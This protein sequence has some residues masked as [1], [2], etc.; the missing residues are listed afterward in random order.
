MPTD[1]LGITRRRLNSNEDKP[2]THFD[3]V[4]PD[5]AKG[6]PSESLSDKIKQDID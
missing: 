1:E 3:Q 5:H 2:S 6:N 4:H